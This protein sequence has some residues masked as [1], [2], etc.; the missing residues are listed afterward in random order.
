M[1]IK[2]ISARLKETSATETAFHPPEDYVWFEYTL[3]QPLESKNSKGR[4]LKLSKGDQFGMRRGTRTGTVKLITENML[5]QTF[6]TDEE[7]A[8][9]LEKHSKEIPTP[10]K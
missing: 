7:L 8:E 6:T 10:K 2:E 9:A 1:S 3:A 4:T 5:G